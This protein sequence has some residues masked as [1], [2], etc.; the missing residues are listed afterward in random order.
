ME[1]KKTLEQIEKLNDEELYDFLWEL[2]YKQSEQIFKGK[3]SPNKYIDSFFA[4]HMLEAEV[5]NGGFDQF[6]QNGGNDFYAQNALFGLQNIEAI[7]FIKLLEKGIEIYKDTPQPHNERNPKF[8][9]IDDEFYDINQDSKKGLSKLNQLQI[10]YFRN[11]L[12]LIK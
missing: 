10:N 8:N 7:E 12:N 3:K 11:N 6:F 5:N 1:H 2:G 9:S 4:I